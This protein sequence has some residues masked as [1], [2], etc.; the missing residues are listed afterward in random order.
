MHN[1]L[2]FQFYAK[3]KVSPLGTRCIKAQGTG[4]LFCCIF[5]VTTL[6]ITHNHKSC[7]PLFE[8]KL[9][10]GNPVHDVYLYAKFVNSK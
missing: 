7:N 4:L 8:Q 1:K 5:V 9:V 2:T 10:F 6:I 3:K